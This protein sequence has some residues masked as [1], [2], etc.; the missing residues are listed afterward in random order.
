VT[1]ALLAGVLGESLNRP[2]TLRDMPLKTPSVY[3]WLRQQPEGPIVEYPA[4]NLEGRS[5]P[6]DATY[7]YYSTGHWRPMLNGYSG[8]E[9]PSYHALLDALRDFPGG[10]SVEFLRQRGAR[11]LLVHERF[12]LRGGFEQDIDALTRADGLY[13][14]AIFRDPD[15]GRTYVYEV[16]R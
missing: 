13:V 12:Y 10:R 1:I 11:Y 16:R 6:Q 9:P 15:L 4:S 3:D 7:M 5:G 2:L 14:S 8:F